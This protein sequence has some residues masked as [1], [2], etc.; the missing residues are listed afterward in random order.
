MTST[1]LLFQR[2][3]S[4][5]SPQQQ[6]NHAQ[7]V[8]VSLVRDVAALEHLRRHSEMHCFRWHPVAATGH[9]LAHLAHAPVIEEWGSLPHVFGTLQVSV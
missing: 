1:R 6:P 4:F 8:H 3:P 5:N 2:G 7:A 9:T